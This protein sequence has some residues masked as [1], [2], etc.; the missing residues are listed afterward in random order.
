M[1]NL[2][3]RT[4]ALLCV[5]AIT[6][7]LAAC[8]NNGGG[9]TNTGSGSGNNGEIDTLDM[10]EYILDSDAVLATMPEELKGTT[11]EFLSWYD[12]DEHEEKD[13]ID[14]F[15]EKTGI[16][17]TYRVVE[18]S[19]Y[20]ETVAGL[21]AVGETPDV[22]RVKS[23]TAATLKLT[24]PIKEATGYDFSDKAWD[25]QTM[26]MYS[27][28]GKCYGVNLVYTPYFLPA[29]LFY[30]SD[31]M[32]EMGF[33]DPYELWKEGKWTWDKLKEMCTTWVNQGTEYT[34]ATLWAN[35]FA[36]TAGDADFTDFDGSQYTLDLNNAVALEKWKWAM[37]GVKTNLFTNLTDGFDQS[38]QRLLFAAMSAANVQQSTDY[39]PK[40]RRREQL[41]C[42]AYPI[43]EGTDYYLPFTEHLAF[44]VPKGAK[45]PKAVP[46]FLSYVCN[47]ANYNQGVG[48]GGFFYSEQAKE[49]YMEL[50]TISNRSRGQSNMVFAYS[51]EIDD[52]AF[53]MLFRV[54]PS[55]LQTW[56]Q[57]REY[58]FQN[59]ANLLNKDLAAL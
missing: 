33:E 57:E 26:D 24:Q 7:S 48:E 10:Q 23:P 1:S 22:M 8:I 12:P 56:L 47:F 17:V 6:V 39:F 54:D 51:G 38:Q 41:K 45:N 3:K 19:K 32:E 5:L 34:G 46:Y 16:T 43:W 9:N 40:T 13:V 55:Q 42:V 27:V 20:V 28:S 31:T 37:E 58:I 59:S 36:A 11:I 50:L 29:L 15:E 52:A 53:Q 25:T 44:C 30:N 14:A 2:I 4:V 35:A 18:Y 21:L 49:C